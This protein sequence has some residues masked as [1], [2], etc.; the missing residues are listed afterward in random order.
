MA[1]FTIPVYSGRV[2]SLAIER[3][4]K[5]R[6]DST[7]CILLVVYGN[8]NFDDALLELYGIVKEQ[9]FQP[10]GAGAFIAE[11]TFSHQIGTN[12][13]DSSDLEKVALFAKK[14]LKQFADKQILQ[15]E[16]IRGN[17]PYKEASK[18]PVVPLVRDSCNTC[19][20]CAAKCPAEAIP[21][22]NFKET[23]LEKCILCARC[24]QICPTKSRFLPPQFLEKVQEMLNKTAIERKE[25]EFFF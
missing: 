3:I 23:I 5:L 20:L 19:G 7:P 24:V 15:K 12:R 14:I 8:R 22:A 4:K 11:H 2:P 21:E 18:A 25:P 9:G 1:I 13:P 10:I 17:F 6:G 16:N